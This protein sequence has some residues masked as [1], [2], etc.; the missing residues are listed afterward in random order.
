MNRNPLLIA[1]F[2][3]S[4]AS[5]AAAAEVT[6][7]QPWARASLTPNG[8]VYLTLTN[9]ASA[10][11]RLVG[12]ETP[13]AGHVM[14]MTNA[15]GHRQLDA[16]DI[17]ADGQ[18]EAKPTGDGLHIMLM[19]LTRK[20]DKGDQLSLT[21]LFAD[22]DRRA[23]A[24]RPPAGWLGRTSAGPGQARR[25]GAPRRTARPVGRGNGN[26]RPAKQQ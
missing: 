21:L 6:V 2:P 5:Q 1:T 23:A 22:G 10:P 14:L 8:G 12:A 16:W 9:K 24:P 26:H 11:A 13:V 25:R 15:G 20:L 17:P 18:I 3:A 7:E 4:F 19:G